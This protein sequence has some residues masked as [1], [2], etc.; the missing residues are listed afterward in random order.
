[1]NEEREKILDATLKSLITHGFV[2]GD[3]VETRRRV[4]GMLNL[5]RES[6][7]NQT[8]EKK[9]FYDAVEMRFFA[10]SFKEIEAIYYDKTIESAD[11]EIKE[12][13]KMEESKDLFTNVI[14]SPD[15]A[16]VTVYLNGEDEMNFK[17]LK[18]FHF[19]NSYYV[20]LE[21]LEDHKTKY[22]RYY[23]ET[24][25]GEKVEKLFL[26]EDQTQISLFK[27]LGN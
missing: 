16:N 12:E 10:L 19:E 15:G 2:P 22:Y 23:S 3:E 17:K 8:A 25:E 4:V 20:L 6:R 21:D 24:Y 1:M 7:L 5:L 27:F 14:K 9:Q 13:E 26:V 18:S 11:L